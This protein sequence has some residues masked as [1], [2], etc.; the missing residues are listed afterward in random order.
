MLD[1]VVRNRACICKGKQVRICSYGICQVRHVSSKFIK[2]LTFLV[3][4]KMSFS[5]GL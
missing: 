1:Q 3:V 4:S 2:L 5:Q